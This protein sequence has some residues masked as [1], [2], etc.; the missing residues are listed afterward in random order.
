MTASLA[1]PGL[2]ISMSSSADLRVQ[3]EQIK[4]VINNTP[5]T[6]PTENTK[7]HFLGE[8]SRSALTLSSAISSLKSLAERQSAQF[9]CCSHRCVEPCQAQSSSEFVLAVR[10]TNIRTD[11]VCRKQY[12]KTHQFNK[13][14]ASQSSSAKCVEEVEEAASDWV[15]DLLRAKSPEGKELLVKCP[16]ECSYYSRQIYQDEEVTSGGCAKIVRLEVE[17]GPRRD[18]INFTVRGEVNETLSC[19]TL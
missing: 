17:C 13:R 6:C 2:C 16:D 15:E 4:S 9:S 8:I 3:T 19:R 18:G 1:N 7:T 14:F 11:V 12:Q 5:L 10:P